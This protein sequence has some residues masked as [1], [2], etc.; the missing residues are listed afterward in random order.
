MAFESEFLD[1]MP[2]KVVYT[3]PTTAVDGYGTITFSA[4]N[5]T[6]MGLV[7]YENKI[8]RDAD[9]NERLSDTQVIINATGVL[10][11]EGRY[12]L[13]DS[14]GTFPTVLAVDRLADNEGQHHI[15]IA[16]GNRGR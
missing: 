14:T 8:I 11:P 1:C 4:T 13:P 5:S 3:P 10:H 16:F 7:Q 6:F 2:H 9:G 12:A 15:E